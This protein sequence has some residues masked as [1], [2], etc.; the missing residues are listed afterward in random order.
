M[1][2][3]DES[4]LPLFADLNDVS[5]Q[6]GGWTVVSHLKSGGTGER[7]IGT[8]G[9]SPKTMGSQGGNIL[10]LDGSARWHSIK[11]L[12]IYHSYSSNNKYKSMWAYR[13]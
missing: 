3:Y 5:E 10:F 2:L 13:D 9:A 12:S 11:S 4:N 1:A 8:A 6:G 7:I